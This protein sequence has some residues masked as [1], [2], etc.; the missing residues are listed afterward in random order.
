MLFS[1]ILDFIF[2]NYCV[3]CHKRIN[4][5]SFTCE[6]CANILQYSKVKILQNHLACDYVFAAFPYQG[7][8]KKAIIA[9]KFKQQ[10]YLKKAFASKLIQV[11]DTYQIQFDSVIPVPISRKRYWER[12]YNQSAEIASIL[13]KKFHKKMYD[14]LLQKIKDNPR[15]STLSKN[16]RQDNVKGVYQV[17][18]TN[19]LKEKTLLL[20]DDIFTTGATVSE[21]A[22]VLKQSGAQK[23]IVLTIAYAR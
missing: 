8:I 19:Q 17:K 20:V 4:Y 11:I 5:D 14:H 18:K 7:I 9:F 15:Q 1:S 16:A 6:K 12:G 22:R 23:V 10:R 2:P 21:C 13:A 3:R